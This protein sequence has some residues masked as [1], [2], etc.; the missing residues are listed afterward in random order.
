[1]V[2]TLRL[3]IPASAGAGVGLPNH[4]FEF[5]SE[6]AGHAP[7]MT[8]EWEFE[9]CSGGA[10]RA[11]DLYSPV[12]PS[13]IPMPDDCGFSNCHFPQRQWSRSEAN[14]FSTFEPN[15]ECSGSGGG[16]LSAGSGPHHS[17]ADGG[18]LFDRRPSVS[19][20]ACGSARSSSRASLMRF[21]RLIPGPI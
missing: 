12:S 15:N 17:V 9:Q 16:S 18:C 5:L 4:P 1:M 7:T 6:C 14:E 8:D 3:V 21:P 20:G 10:A 19:A 13:V 2:K 11:I